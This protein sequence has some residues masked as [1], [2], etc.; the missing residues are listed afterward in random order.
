M[1]TTLR[2]RSLLR[3]GLWVAAFI[4]LGC[5]SRPYIGG[6]PTPIPKTEPTGTLS[7]TVTPNE[8]APK[9]ELQVRWTIH[10]GHPMDWIGLFRVGNSNADYLDSK[11]T[12][13]TTSGTQ[14]WEAPP[15]AG[16]Y[17]FRYFAL[18]DFGWYED[19]VHSNAVT[20]AGPAPSGDSTQTTSRRAGRGGTA[21]LLRK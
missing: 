6:G 4:T 13:G 14:T 1:L 17:E 3:A 21:Q 7:L 11:Y 9:G 18:L 2:E 8:V 20:V 15:Q 16:Q 12:D 19:A 5:D 10:A